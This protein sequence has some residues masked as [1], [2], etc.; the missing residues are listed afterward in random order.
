MEEPQ[1]IKGQQ[2]AGMSLANARE[3]AQSSAHLSLPL[4][5]SRSPP[6]LQPS[7]MAWLALSFG[8]GTEDGQRERLTQPSHSLGTPLP[9]AAFASAE[10]S[11]RPHALLGPGSF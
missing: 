1:C 9:P 4:S 2:Q 7:N 10:M 6:F 5:G 8:L 3:G 11:N